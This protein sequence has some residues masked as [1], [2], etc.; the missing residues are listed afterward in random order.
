MGEGAA[1]AAVV[2]ECEQLSMLAFAEKIESHV[3]S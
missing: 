1:A 3:F 2:L